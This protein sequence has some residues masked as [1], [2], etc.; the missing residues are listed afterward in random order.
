MRYDLDKPLAGPE[1]YYTDDDTKQLSAQTQYYAPCF[2]CHSISLDGTKIGLTFGGSVPSLF[3][4]L[5]VAT[6]K[7]L[8]AGGRTALRVSDR[9]APGFRASQRVAT[10]TVVSAGSAVVVHAFPGQLLP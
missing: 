1:A 2:G 4:L 6:K 3:A 5:D 8:A 7:P 9:D 10:Q